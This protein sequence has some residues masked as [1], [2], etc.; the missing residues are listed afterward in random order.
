M[1]LY[2]TRRENKNGFLSLFLLG[3][4]KINAICGPTLWQSFII[5]RRNFQTLLP[6]TSNKKN[7]ICV[8]LFQ[9]T[10][11]ISWL[12]LLAF[13]FSFCVVSFSSDSSGAEA[14]LTIRH[15]Q[16]KA[17]ENAPNKLQHDYILNVFVFLNK[18]YVR[19]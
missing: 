7:W 5:N 19:W 13:K 14:D 8:Y 15:R 1:M 18:Q 10:L 17:S 4:C 16:Q 9:S 6:N 3:E 11:I 2:F 12:L